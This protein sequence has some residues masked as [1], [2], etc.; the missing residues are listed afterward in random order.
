VTEG[1]GVKAAFVY[2]RAD[3]DSHTVTWLPPRCT[4]PV[5][6]VRYERMGFWRSFGK[7]KRQCKIDTQVRYPKGHIFHDSSRPFDSV[8]I[9]SANQYILLRCLP[10]SHSCLKKKANPAPR[11]EP[12]IL[13]H[14]HKQKKKITCIVYSRGLCCGFA[15]LLPSAAPSGVT[16]ILLVLFCCDFTSRSGTYIGGEIGGRK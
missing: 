16:F 2:T 14:V 9:V 15:N 4:C 3:G 1:R 13:R 12:T 10:P 6:S 5:A 11:L 7:Y 8:R